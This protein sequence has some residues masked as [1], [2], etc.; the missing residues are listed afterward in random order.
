MRDWIGRG[1]VAFKISRNIWNGFQTAFCGTL[2]ENKVA[3]V[4]KFVYLGL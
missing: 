1:G 3:S 2:K 4:G